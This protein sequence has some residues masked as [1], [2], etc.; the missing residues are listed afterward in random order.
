MA[1]PKFVVV[2][3]L[4]VLSVQVQAESPDALKLWYKQPA[5]EWTQALPIGNGRLGAMVYGGIQQEQLQINEDTLWHGG[6][7]DYSNPEAYSHLATV[8][9]LL[10]N[11]EYDKAEAEA[12]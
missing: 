5:A 2:L 12:E 7:H 10:E 6:P 1:K 3:C 8:R 4:L 11:G 9:Q